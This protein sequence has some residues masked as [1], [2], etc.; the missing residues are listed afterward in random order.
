MDRPSDS[1][2][3][4]RT[5]KADAIERIAVAYKQR[6][7][8]RPPKRLVVDTAIAVLDAATRLGFMPDLVKVRQLP[9]GWGPE[10]KP[11]P[12]RDRLSGPERRGEPPREPV[13]DPLS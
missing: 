3:I 6:T 10:D 8:M 4:V 11:A 13:D 7:G 1:Q 2:I 5:S 9:P 12:K